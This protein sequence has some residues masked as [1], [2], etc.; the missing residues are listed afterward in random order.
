ML[1]LDENDTMTRVGRGTP[2]GELLRRY[3]HPVCPVRELS[4]E[5]RKKRIRLLGEDLVLFRDGKGRVGLV[6]EQCA[7]R[8]ASLYYGFVEDEGLRCPYHG[9]KYDVNGSCIEQPFEPAGSPL[10][11]EVCQS[12]YP[13]QQLAGLFWA[14]LGPH[15]VPFLPRWELLVSTG[16]TRRIAVQ[17]LLQCNW[18]QA[19]ENSVD[20]THTYYLHGHMMVTK[21]HPERGAYYYRPIENLEFEVVKE[22][23]WGGIRKNRTYGG[24]TVEKEL[25]HPLI[26]PTMLL[27]PQGD[28]VALHFRV[29]VDDSHTQI[30]RVE[31]KPGGDTRG[32]DWDD[33]PVEY[34][35]PNKDENGEYCL[36]T[37]YSQDGMAWET[38]GPLFD[39]SKENLGVSDRGLVLFRRMLKEQIEAVQNGQDPLGTI[40]D[41]KENK[42]IVIPVTRSDGVGTVS[43]GGKHP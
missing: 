7:H 21:G 5:T 39:R 37:F 32:V 30:Y 17:E 38:Q 8:R 2:A 25:G 40:R 20:P 12:A 19:M 43:A 26:F 23:A 42:T 3:W 29:P 36:D 27:V 14:Y 6:A 28:V 15:P 9:W 1:S 11:N 24:K 35:P 31:F 13:V 16:G 18:L 4:P 34:D 33:P 10:K 41:P 22:K